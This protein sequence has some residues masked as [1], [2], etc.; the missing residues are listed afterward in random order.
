[1]PINVYS[2]SVTGTIEASVG[3]CSLLAAHVKSDAVNSK[4]KLG[5]KASICSRFN[6]H[7]RSSAQLWLLLSSL[8]CSS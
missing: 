3:L 1:V 7:A 8:A 2:A 4:F 5:P 6:T